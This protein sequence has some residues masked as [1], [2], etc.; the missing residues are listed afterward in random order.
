MV[1]Q[2]PAVHVKAALSPGGDCCCTAVQF[3]SGQCFYGVL[4]STGIEKLVLA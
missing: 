4:M 3:V 1:V 2:A